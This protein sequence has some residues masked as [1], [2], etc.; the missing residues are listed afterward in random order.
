VGPG[1]AFE[2]EQGLPKL[3][4]NFRLGFYAATA[5]CDGRFLPKGISEPT[6]SCHQRNPPVTRQNRVEAAF[7]DRTQINKPLGALAPSILLDEHT[8][9]LF[10]PSL[11]VGR[12]LGTIC[13]A[14]I[15]EAGLI[16]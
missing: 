8:V 4:G 16:A 15:L 1:A 14:V 13:N 2:G 12:M 7:T 10:A 9:A 5:S 11:L 3:G 6:C